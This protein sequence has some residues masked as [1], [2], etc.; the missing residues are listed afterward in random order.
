MNRDQIAG[1]CKQLSGKVKEQWGKLTH[2]SQREFD[3]RCEQVLGR[4]QSRYGIAKE[5]ATR[6]LQDFL[7]R[8]RNW[9]ITDK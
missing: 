8:N 9:R 4:I 5:Q 6:Q 7:H 3:G 1:N 2:N